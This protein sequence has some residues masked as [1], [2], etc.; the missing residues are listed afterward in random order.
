MT[1]FNDMMKLWHDHDDNFQRYDD[2]RLHDQM[3][4][5]NDIM[6]NFNPIRWQLSMIWWQTLTRSDDNFQRYDDKL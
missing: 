1:T 3:T 5:F 2:K 4:T 6:T